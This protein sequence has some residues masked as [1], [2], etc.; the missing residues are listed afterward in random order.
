MKFSRSSRSVFGAVLRTAGS[1]FLILGHEWQGV[2]AFKTG[3]IVRVPYKLERHDDI[4]FSALLRESKD[5]IERSVT[6]ARLGSTRPNTM[7]RMNPQ[8]EETTSLNS[9]SAINFPLVTQNLANQAL[10]GFQI[11]TGGSGFRVL[12][13]ESHFGV[14]AIILGIAGMI[15]MIALS[16]AIETSES[17]LVSGL[18]LSTNMAVLR[19][20]G[21]T[22]KPILAFL[23]SLLMA[24][25]TGIVEETV[26]RGQCKCY[27]VFCRP[28]KF[29]S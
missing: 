24:A 5:N 8:S 17:P 7:L 22:S 14:G 18:N 27:M 19:L 20:F 10:I 16:R 4:R 26:F 2:D 23:V 11:W 25:S 1:I 29:S 13:E 9:S 28:T 3:T 15:P 6:N 21:P 12:S